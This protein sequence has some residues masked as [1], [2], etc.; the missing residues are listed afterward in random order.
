MSPASLV[1][2]LTHMGDHTYMTL[3]LIGT[4]KLLYLIIHEVAGGDWRVKSRERVYMYEP[5]NI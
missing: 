2:I 4:S 1:R 3:N 5:P